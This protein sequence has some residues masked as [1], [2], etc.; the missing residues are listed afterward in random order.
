MN[1]YAVLGAV[2]LDVNVAVDAV[3]EHTTGRYH[4]GGADY[5]SQEQGKIEMPLRGQEEPAC[6]R[7][8][9][10]ENDPRFGD[11]DKVLEGHRVLPHFAII[12]VW[13]LN[14]IHRDKPTSSTITSA[15]NTSAVTL[16]R[17]AGE[18]SRCRKYTR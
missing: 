16:L 7:K 17:C 12:S 8:H 10:T 15:A 9:V 5:R 14:M 11:L 3:V 18:R 2:H 4:Q 1:Q 13:M 6:H